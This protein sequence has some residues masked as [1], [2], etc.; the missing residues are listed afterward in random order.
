[1]AI[2]T[3]FDA[4]SQ[5]KS[6]HTNLQPGGISLYHAGACSPPPPCEVQ[7]STL[8]CSG[9]KLLKSSTMGASNVRY[10]GAR[11]PRA[12]GVG[13]TSLRGC[14]AGDALYFKVRPARRAYAA[15]LAAHV[16]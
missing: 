6:T 13:L 11:R 14:S 5:A 2:Y 12:R 4:L 3:L 10:A 1:M 9:K 7:S 15:S 16:D 8:L